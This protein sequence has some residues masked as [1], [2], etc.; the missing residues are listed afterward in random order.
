MQPAGKGDGG[1]GV[2]QDK[3]RGRGT[4]FS[5]GGNMDHELQLLHETSLLLSKLPAAV[6]R[7]P[8][9]GFED[10]A[11][12]C[13][14]SA[15][16]KLQTGHHMKERSWCVVKVLDWASWDWDWPQTSCVTLGKSLSFS[17]PGSHL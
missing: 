16:L 2:G 13:E 3:G 14:M 11:L 12:P 1:L 4:G 17:L 15:A 9:K 5:R 7:L 10:V 8:K 6:G